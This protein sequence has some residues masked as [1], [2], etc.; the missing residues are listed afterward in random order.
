M[1]EA[2]SLV[3]VLLSFSLV[4]FLLLFS[5]LL[6]IEKLIALGSSRYVSTSVSPLSSV[7]AKLISFVGTSMVNHG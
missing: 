6:D 1:G 3:F 5:L 7:F 2:A 4:S